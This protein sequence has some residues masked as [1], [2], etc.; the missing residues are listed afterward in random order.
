MTF[1]RIWT[2]PDRGGSVVHDP[3]SD[4]PDL[5]AFP[6]PTLTDKMTAYV[7][8]GGRF[9]A[10]DAQST[11]VDTDAFP[12]LVDTDQVVRPN[13]IT[14]PVDPGR[15]L[16]VPGPGGAVPAHAP[17]HAAAGSDPLT[18]T[19]DQVNN[20]A[21]RTW[22]KVVTLLQTGHS[23]QSLTPVVAAQGQTIDWTELPTN[24]AKYTVLVNVVDVPAPPGAT[25]ELY[26]VT[27]ALVLGTLI[28]NLAN[29]IQN[30]TLT[31]IPVGLATVAF[32]HNRIA[33]GPLSSEVSAVTLVIAD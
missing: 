28:G 10:W 16:G 26:D 27:N 30:F 5:A 33:P 20:H 15:W 8:V 17:T 31:S 24:L 12:A 29:G 21:D 6:V 19:A 7:E 32:R 14:N 3:A 2:L 13:D 23:T 1:P 25:Y 22:G 9:Y 18:L 4:I 11:A